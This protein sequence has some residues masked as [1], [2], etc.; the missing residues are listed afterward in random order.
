[1]QPKYEEKTFESYFNSEL[2]RKASVYFPFGQ[3]QEGGIGADAS[4]LLRNRRLWRRFGYRYFFKI[5][6][7]GTELS[8]IAAEM[9][10]HL[11]IEINNIPRMK[12]NVLFQYKR[13]ELITSSRGAEW[14]HWNKKYF[15]YNI[16]QKQQELLAHIAVKFGNEA[17]VLYA[18]PALEDVNDLV[19]AKRRGTI[20]KDTNFRPALDLTG[21][22]KNTYIKAGTYSIACSEPER[23]E[24]FELL[25]RLD[26][27]ENNKFNNNEETIVK[28]ATGVRRAVME[29]EDLR[30]AYTSELSVYIEAGVQN[31]PLVFAM[32]S[33]S[34]FREISG[35][36]WVIAIN[37]RK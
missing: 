24:Q 6:Y 7:S 25:A 28:F 29:N 16:Y 35:V 20:I 27:L 19:S 18:S 10:Q 26:G 23:L 17:L 5:P 9:E 31:F 14:A 8:D 37:A 34:I 11:G 33:M 4:A 22:H 1:M 12:A 2:D 15:R 30:K 3:V 32:V 21:H 36:Q 13:P